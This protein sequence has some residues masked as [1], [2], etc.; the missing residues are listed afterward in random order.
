MTFTSL[1]PAAGALAAVLAAI[2]LFGRL[3]KAVPFIRRTGQVTSRLGLVDSL[4][5][6][7]RRR[8]LLVQCDGRCVLLLTGQQDQVVG[9]LADRT[10]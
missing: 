4:T 9:W 6:D 1:L 10:A 3:A 2:V 8:L 5:L 7:P